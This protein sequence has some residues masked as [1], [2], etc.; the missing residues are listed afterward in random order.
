MSKC[1]FKEI[2]DALDKIAL[3]NYYQNHLTSDVCEHFKFDAKYFYRIF[4]YVLSQN[5][6]LI[7]GQLL[8][9]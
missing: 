8:N 6:G 1:I 7:R 3:E 4:H 9:Q 2:A 5:N